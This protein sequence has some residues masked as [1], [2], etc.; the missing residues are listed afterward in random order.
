MNPVLAEIDTE[1]KEFETFL[2][3][4]LED[5]QSMR[6]FLWTLLPEARLSPEEILE[7][8]RRDSE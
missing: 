1:L 4:I 7:V 6:S 3:E 8:A 2:T 5:A